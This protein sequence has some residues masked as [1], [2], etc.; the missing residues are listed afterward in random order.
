MHKSGTFCILVL[1]VWGW[2]RHFNSTTMKNI[3]YSY[4]VTVLYDEGFLPKQ[5]NRYG[6]S[7]LPRK[8]THKFFS[9]Q[10]KTLKD[11]QDGPYY[12]HATVLSLDLIE[13]KTL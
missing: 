7:E 9:I 8:Q 13:N 11:I 2:S 5:I 1:L 10:P 6:S 12:P 3:K 4:L